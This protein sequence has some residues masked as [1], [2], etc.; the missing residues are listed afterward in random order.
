MPTFEKI[1]SVTAQRRKA[2]R[3]EDEEQPLEKWQGVVTF[4][5]TYVLWNETYDGTFV[6]GCFHF[7]NGP[8][9]AFSCAMQMWRVMELKAFAEKGNPNAE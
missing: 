8:V 4:R 2:R 1:I 7:H 5:G 9:D 6:E 3:G